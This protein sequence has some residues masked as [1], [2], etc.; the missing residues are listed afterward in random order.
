MASL[1]ELDNLVCYLRMIMKGFVL[2]FLSE[3][4]GES[5]VYVHM[6]GKWKDRRYRRC[7]VE[8][9]MSGQLNEKQKTSRN[10]FQQRTKS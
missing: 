1:T 2:T 5:C 3:N 6:R 10:N 9:G 7:R 4:Y 8:V